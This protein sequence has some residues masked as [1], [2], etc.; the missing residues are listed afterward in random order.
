MFHVSKTFLTMYNSVSALKGEI[1]LAAFN[2]EQVN[3]IFMLGGAWPQ[4]WNCQI[5]NNFLPT[6]I[7]SIKST[8]NTEFWQATFIWSSSYTPGTSATIT[9]QCSDVHLYS[10]CCSRSLSK[11][12]LDLALIMSPT[13]H[14]QFLY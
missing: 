6:L 14:K 8:W 1:F 11:L 10:C 2:L 9:M 5:R 13:S 3:A 4:H 12:D 7:L